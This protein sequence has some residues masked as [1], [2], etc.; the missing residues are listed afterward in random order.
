MI[1]GASEQDRQW[2]ICFTPVS[3]HFDTKVCRGNK[4]CKFFGAA[5]A[6]SLYEDK[7]LNLSSRHR[8]RS[9]Q[10][11]RA[12]SMIVIRGRVRYCD[13]GIVAS[14]LAG[15]YLRAKADAMR[16]EARGF[17]AESSPAR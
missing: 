1:P 5:H 10:G 11:Y 17:S 9:L 8:R 2:P 3:T 13:A 7:N 14:N 15:I 12:P 4:G 6:W 16:T